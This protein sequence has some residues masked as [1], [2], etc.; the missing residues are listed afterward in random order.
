M[1]IFIFF[2]FL[3]FDKNWTPS[4][5]QKFEDE[6]LKKLKVPVKKGG[7]KWIF[8]NKLYKIK[9]YIKIFT[10]KSFSFIKLFIFNFIIMN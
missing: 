8:I 4:E 2:S 5:C 1:G 9:I 3:A 7:K 10:S 6:E